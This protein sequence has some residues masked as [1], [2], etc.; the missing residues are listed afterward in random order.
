MALPEA[1]YQATSALP[2]DSCQREDVSGMLATSLLPLIL[3]LLSRSMYIPATIIPALSQTQAQPA[4]CV[5]QLPSSLPAPP[6]QP[7]SRSNLSG[8]TV[9]SY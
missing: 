6:P 4:A 5:A 8:Y 1:L 2:A 3:L 7:P 9:P